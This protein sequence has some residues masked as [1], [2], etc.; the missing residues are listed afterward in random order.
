MTGQ[1]L[2]T[3]IPGR[4]D[5]ELPGRLIVIEGTDCVG[6]STQI[7][8]L[9]DWLENQGY[10]VVTTSLARSELAE[11]GLRKAK[12]RNQAGRRTLCL[13]YAT[14]LADR[15]ERSILP[16]LENG[17]IVLADRYVYTIFARYAVRGI[18]PAWLRK[19]YGFALAPHLLL[20]LDVKLDVL[21]KRALKA[22]KMGFWE[23]GM[24]LDL[25]N[26][27]YESFMLYQKQM[28]HQFTTIAKEYDFVKVKANA[29]AKFVHQRLCKKI[30]ALLDER[31]SELATTAAASAARAQQQEPDPAVG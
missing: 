14:D 8:L 19:A 10:G 7:R 9:Q 31:D 1:W 27:L 2:S 17:F 28:L 20:Y 21:A 24:D 5:T 25:S 11:Q 4:G 13:F 12:R 26:N 6:R 15:L 23:S 22:E 29:S 3:G 16:A 18:D 30:Q